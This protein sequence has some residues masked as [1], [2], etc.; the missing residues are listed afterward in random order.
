MKYRIVCRLLIGLGLTALAAAASAQDRPTLERIETVMCAQAEQ[1]GQTYRPIFCD[2]RCDCLPSGSLGYIDSCE[3]Q[4]SGKVVIADAPFVTNAEC[5]GTCPFGVD[6]CRSDADCS[7]ESCDFSF[8]QCTVSHDDVTCVL[9]EQCD[10]AKGYYCR[11]LV[12]PGYQQTVGVCQGVGLDLC[13]AQG[14]CDTNVANTSSYVE[15]DYASAGDVTPLQCTRAGSSSIAFSGELNSSDIGACIEAAEVVLG[16]N[17]CVICGDGNLD[18]GE[19]CDDGNLDPGDG[20]APDC[21]T[22]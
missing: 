21:T 3:Q 12:P 14:T 18:A 7:G 17:A 10:Q 5:W 11:S 22:E 20:C 4:P 13:S 2:P 9:D 15:F 19:Q 16:S 6:P 8:G 1:Q